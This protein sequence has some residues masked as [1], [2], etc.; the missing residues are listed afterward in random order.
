[1]PRTST[2]NYSA[3]NGRAIRLPRVCDL[4]A[5]SGPTVW[6]RT[7]QDPSFPKPFSLSPNI[8]VWDEAEVLA[9]LQ[10][11]KTRRGAA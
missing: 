1:M 7:R 11:K 10:A 3:V 4:T 6:R 5:Q 8:T 9:W 2:L